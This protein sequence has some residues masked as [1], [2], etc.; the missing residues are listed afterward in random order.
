MEQSPES[1]PACLAARL[2][3]GLPGEGAQL[4]MC[5][6]YRIGLLHA[7]PEGLPW[8]Q[9]AVL[10]LLYPDRKREWRFCLIERSAHRGSHRGEMALPGG[11]LEPGE[12]PLAAALREAREELGLE[13]GTTAAIEVL[14]PLSSLRV[15]PSGFEIHPFVAVLGSEPALRPEADEVA[16]CFFPR[17]TDLLDPASSRKETV[18]FQGRAWEL[19]FFGLEGTRVWGA[20]AM[21]LAELAAVLQGSPGPQIGLEEAGHGLPGQ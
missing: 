3:Q 5:P 20:T 19:P 9:S 11:S 13:A 8:R 15:P 18:D 1:L 10:L 2:A 17:L 16:A 12:T 14:G 6:P 21:I 4:A 7:R